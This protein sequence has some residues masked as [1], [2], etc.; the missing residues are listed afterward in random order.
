VFTSIPLNPL[1][2][3]P[4]ET[5]PVAEADQPLTEALDVEP[6]IARS[7]VLGIGVSAINMAIALDT[8]DK[9]VAQRVPNYVCVT[10]VHGVMESRRDAELRAIHNHAGLV[11][12]DGMPLVW[13]SRAAGFRHVERVYGPELMRAVCERSVT[14]GYRHF[15]YG[16]AP[17]VGEKLECRLR[18]LYPGIEIVGHYCPPFRPLTPAEDDEVV[19]L[20]NAAAPDLVWVGLSTPTQERWMAAHTNRLSAPVLVGVGAAFDFIAGVKKQAPPWMRRSGLEWMFRLLSEPR[21]LWRRYLVNNPRFVALIAKQYLLGSH[22]VPARDVGPPQDG[23]QTS[24]CADCSIDDASGHSRLARYLD[25]DAA[26]LEY[27]QGKR[28]LHLGCVGFTDCTI[29]RKVALASETLHARLSAISTCLGVDLDRDSLAQM[30]SRRVFLNA[31]AGDAEHLENTPL[32]HASFDVVVAADIIEHV[33][34]PGN[35][36]D[37]IRPLLA[38][39]GRLIVSTP[40]AMGLPNFL[41]YA[42]GSFTEG[43]QHVLCFNPVTLRQL[44]ERHGYRVVKAFTCHQPYASQAG[45]SF[46]IGKAL[47]ERVPKFGGTLLYIAQT[48]TNERPETAAT[49]STALSPSLRRSSG[50]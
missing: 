12:P 9:W 34:N 35:M 45:G 3:R 16:G 31:I 8:I 2:R 10:G 41:R 22:S 37:G 30:H 4:D 6:G 11:T 23:L 38:A 40:N 36:L 18:E 33:S 15:V 26:L 42:K 29:D 14:R 17:G 28:V 50:C 27:C 25:R 47:L 49:V 21:R 44:L 5:A 20:I 13:L 46:R 32:R 19:K 1:L 39:N 24:T 48:Y 43:R 7:N